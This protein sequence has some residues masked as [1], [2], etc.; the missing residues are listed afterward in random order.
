MGKQVEVRIDG[1]EVGEVM[2]FVVKRYGSVSTTG[3]KSAA[4]LLAAA[5]L[6]ILMCVDFWPFTEDKAGEI[7]MVRSLAKDIACDLYERFK[8]S[9][10]SL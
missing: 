9:G 7:E 4:L 3:I 1:R 2:A 6:D 8:A 5:E 10:E